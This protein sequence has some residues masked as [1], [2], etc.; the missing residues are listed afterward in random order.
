MAAV[1]GNGCALQQL[2]AGV[3]AGLLEPRDFAPVLGAGGLCLAVFRGD[4][5]QLALGGDGALRFHLGGVV[6]CRADSGAAGLVGLAAFGLVGAYFLRFL[7]MALPGHA[8]FARMGMALAVG[9]GGGYRAGLGA[10]S[11]E[12]LP[13]GALFSSIKGDMIF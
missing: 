13:G 1:C 8:R 9:A 4:V 6:R 7:L 11:A 5:F 2:A 12:L 3:P 10:G